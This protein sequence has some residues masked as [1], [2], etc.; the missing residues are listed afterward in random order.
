[1]TDGRTGPLVSALAEGVRDDLSGIAAL[2]EEV[3]IRV[4]TLGEAARAING[5]ADDCRGWANH[6]AAIRAE[7]AKVQAETP[8]KLLGQP[9]NPIV[10]SVDSEHAERVTRARRSA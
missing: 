1:M 2:I 9:L 4:E 10:Q 3:Q 8:A 7:V 5:L 6:L